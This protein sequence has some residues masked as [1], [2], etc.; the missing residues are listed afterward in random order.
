MYSNP[1]H[2]GIY[3]SEERCL[4]LENKYDADNQSGGSLADSVACGRGNK[5][6]I[7]N[8]SYYYLGGN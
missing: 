7:A 3:T 6:I 1:A 2:F 4:L 5:V 8:I